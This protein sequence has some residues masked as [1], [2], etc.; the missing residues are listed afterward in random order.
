MKALSREQIFTNID[1]I[2]THIEQF[3][4]IET[5]ALV[6]EYL[7]AITS[8]QALATETQASAKYWLL[9][10]IDEELERQ[11]KLMGNDKVPPSI[12]KMRADAKC[13]EWHF[14]YERCERLSRA[15]SHTIDATRTKVSYLKEEMSNA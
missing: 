7:S 13:R 1:C 8:L 9:E 12:K 6:L 11:A 14:I 2:H 15:I 3:A 10:A 5:P 4:G